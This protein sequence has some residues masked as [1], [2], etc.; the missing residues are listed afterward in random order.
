MKFNPQSIKFKRIK[1]KKNI[2]NFKNDKKRH[3]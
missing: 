2:F 3:K 1:L